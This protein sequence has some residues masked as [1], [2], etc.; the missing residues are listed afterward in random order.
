MLGDCCSI[1]TSRFKV[2]QSNP[3]CFYT[4]LLHARRVVRAFFAHFLCV[5][6]LTLRGVVVAD[7]LDRLPDH[8]LVVD[9]RLRGDLTAEQDH[10]GFRYRFCKFG[11]RKRLRVMCGRG[12]RYRRRL[13]RP[14]PAG[15]ERPVSHR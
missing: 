15:G 6:E 8:F 13:L 12:C 9:D 2:L 7:V 10:S 3:D 5:A 14:G 11:K 4:Q 1:A